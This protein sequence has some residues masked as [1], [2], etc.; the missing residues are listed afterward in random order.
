MPVNNAKPS[1]GRRGYYLL[2]DAPPV[3]NTLARIFA[4]DWAPE[5]F[6]D[7]RPVTATDPKYGEPPPG[8]TL[9]L[10]PEYP[11]QEAPFAQPVTARGPARFVVVSAPENAM[12][13]DDGL[14]ALLQRAGAG[15]EIMLEQLYEHKYWGDSNSNPIAD[16]NPRLEAVIDAAR[17][18]AQV[19]LLLDS[20]FDDGENLRSNR[21]TVDYVRAIAAAEGLDLDA[22]LGNPTGGGIHAKI[23]ADPGRRRDVV[24]RR[25]P[26]WGRSQ[27]QDQPRGGVDGG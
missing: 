10:P 11:V 22:R 24:G 15:D 8:F 20:F 21:A 9:P 12:Q 7:L 18:G 25:Q 6:L 13:P 16:P 1:G 26:Q 5:Q 19:R 4:L 3:V 27:P 23:V 17:R 2:T 14:F